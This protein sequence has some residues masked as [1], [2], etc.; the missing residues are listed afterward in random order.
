MFDLSGLIVFL[1][2]TICITCLLS[3]Y[4][5]S[6]LITN[7]NGNCVA[8]AGLV[9]KKIP[10]I[11]EALTEQ[12]KQQAE[13]YSKKANELYKDFQLYYLSKDLRDI[14]ETNAVPKT[15]IYQFLNNG[16]SIT[17]TTTEK[18]SLSY[19][20]PTIPSNDSDFFRNCELFE[21]FLHTLLRLNN[22][23][24]HFFIS[25]QINDV[26]TKWG[27]TDTCL[28]YYYFPVIE[29]TVTVVWIVLIIISRRQGEHRSYK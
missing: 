3:S 13:F 5:F 2:I 10:N 1:L 27:D 25:D 19:M 15:Q 6:S 21:M 16:P 12:S 28:F 14:D 17:R 18:S 8:G 22:K 23:N 11:D 4:A 24:H 20:V 7:F 26:A 9:F 29:I